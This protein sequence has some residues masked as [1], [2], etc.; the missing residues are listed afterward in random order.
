M[1]GLAVVGSQ[2]GDEGKGKIIDYLAEKADMVVRGQGGNNAGHTVVI[3]DK[4]YALHLIPSG[5]LNQGAVNII[6]NGVVFDPE[7]FFK[8]IENLEKD[9]IETSNIFI[10]DRAH[11]V[12]PYHKILDELYE[13]A[14]GKDDIGTTKKGIGPCYMDKIERSG[15]RTCDMLDENS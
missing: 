9:G 4:K 5:V 3:G 13:A 1:P 14:R 12:F 11:I 7:G 15:I 2:W 10:S 6:G 8:E